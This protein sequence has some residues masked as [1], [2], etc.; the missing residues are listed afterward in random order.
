MNEREYLIATR[1]TDPLEGYAE[2]GAIVARVKAHPGL[3]GMALRGTSQQGE[4]AD[5]VKKLVIY[6]RAASTPLAGLS[7]HPEAGDNLAR[8]AALVHYVLGIVTEAA[9]LAE[10]VWP[11]LADGADLD[12]VNLIEEIGDLGWYE[13]RLLDLLGSSFE[14]ARA[15]NIAKLRRRYPDGFTEADAVA[16]D[17][18]TER[19]TL[20]AAPVNEILVRLADRLRLDPAS[21]TLLAD[22]EAAIDR[23]LVNADRREGAHRRTVDLLRRAER[24][25]DTL[26]DAV[27]SGGPIVTPLA[28]AIREARETAAGTDPENPCP[29]IPGGHD[30]ETP[31]DPPPRASLWVVIARDTPIT[32]DP[33]KVHRPHPAGVLGVVGELP[34]ALAIAAGHTGAAVVPAALDAKGEVVLGIDLSGDVWNPCD[35]WLATIRAN[36]ELANAT[37]D[38]FSAVSHAAACLDRVTGTGLDEQGAVE[39]ARRALRPFTMRDRLH[40]PQRP[41][42]RDEDRGPAM[43]AIVVALAAGFGLGIIAA[44]LAAIGHVFE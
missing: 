41:A 10:A 5:A 24:E 4:F 19:A 1:R 27:A 6:G 21:P 37:I 34:E 33:D 31:S 13:A 36:A 23:H 18:D 17:L 11:K 14:D 42:A 3:I 26:R 43:L 25:V 40:A 9:E 22:L 20:E 39:E 2:D 7:V 44:V 28:D 30:S 16:R 32:V 8:H 15:R 38:V 35:G 29:P 12:R